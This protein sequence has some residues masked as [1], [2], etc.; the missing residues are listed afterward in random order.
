MA[1]G[2]KVSNIH[3]SGL[4]LLSIIAIFSEGPDSPSKSQYIR[5]PALLAK[6]QVP[7]RAKQIL[8]VTD[9]GRSPNTS[10]VFLL[11]LYQCPYMMLANTF[12]TTLPIW[13]TSIRFFPGSRRKYLQGLSRWWHTPCRLIRKVAISTSTPTFSSL[14]WSR[15][16]GRYFL[17]FP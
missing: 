11:M 9:I 10:E 3:L 4:V 17:L 6:P 13:I 5:S 1:I 16:L 2:R 14:F 8:E 12:S 15:I 7:G